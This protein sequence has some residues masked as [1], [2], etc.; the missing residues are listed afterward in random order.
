[1]LEAPNYVLVHRERGR[2]WKLCV[3]CVNSEREG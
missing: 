3:V 1:M 2:E